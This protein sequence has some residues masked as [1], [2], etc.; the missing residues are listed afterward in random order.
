LPAGE[1]EVAGPRVGCLGSSVSVKVVPGQTTFAVI[2][3]P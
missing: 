3:H 1:Y 2:D